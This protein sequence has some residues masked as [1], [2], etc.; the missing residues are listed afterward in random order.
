MATVYEVPGSRVRPDRWFFGGMA[1]AM[2]AF[3]FVGFAPT[4]YLVSVLHGT[5][6][7][8]VSGGA[9]LTPLVH[10]HGITTAAWIL[11]FGVQTAFI[12][13][14]RRDLHRV[15]GML[16]VPALVGLVLTSVLVA[17]HAARANSV[18]PGW[19]GAQ[20]LL[21]QFGTLGGFVVL[22][23]LGLAW[24][25]R[26]DWHKRLMLLATISTLLPAGAR[27]ARMFD[28]SFLPRGV[29]GG[30]M[31]TSLFVFALVAYDLRSRGRVHPVT[32]WAGGALL[33][34]LPLR[35]M[36]ARTEAWEAVGRAILT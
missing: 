29:P 6:S 7:R 3:V 8:G 30:M 23:I 27:I 33:L 13:A 16:A 5:T 26:A 32:V 31:L 35:L 11:L 24:R 17:L 15:A 34:L 28:L 1:L 21:I 10:L 12:A 4:Y 19:N 14:H 18:P 36:L 9:S 22:A 2:T 25:R 20:F